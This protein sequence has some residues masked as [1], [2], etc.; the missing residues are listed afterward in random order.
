MLDLASAQPKHLYRFVTDITVTMARVENPAVSRIIGHEII[1]A[2]FGYWPTFHDAEITKAAF[3]ANPGH[4]PSVR[5][6]IAAFEMTAEV[7]AKGYYQQAKHCTIEL[8]FEGVREI[9]FEGFSHQNVILSLEFEQ[10]ES[11]IHCTLDSSAGLD[12]FIV[13]QQV[14][15]LSLTPTKR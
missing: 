11:Q 15:V 7:D 14:S 9:E 6:T 8:L 2:H 3:E 13:A 12:A 10:N 4:W 5:F 1:R